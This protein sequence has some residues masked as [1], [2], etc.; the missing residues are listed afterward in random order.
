MTDRDEIDRRNEER[1]RVNREEIKTVA[2]EERR[3]IIP[4]ER[5]VI[6]SALKK[7]RVHS[8]E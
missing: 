2:L 6:L 8:S 7:K 1:R 3:K 4:I 5:E